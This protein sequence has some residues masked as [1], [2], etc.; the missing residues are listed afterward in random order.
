MTNPAGEMP[1]PVRGD[2]CGT[3][4]AV[5]DMANCKTCGGRGDVPPFIAEVPEDHAKALWDGAQIILDLKYWLACEAKCDGT[6]VPPRDWF[7]KIERAIELF[8][9]GVKG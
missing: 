4:Y 6:S 7:H 9:K 5:D 2:R 1:W 8:S 3:C